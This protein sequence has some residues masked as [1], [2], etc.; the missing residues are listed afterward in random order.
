MSHLWFYY[1]SFTRLLWVCVFCIFAAS[2]AYAQTAPVNFEADKVETNQDT[3]ILTASGNV[4]L[5]QDGNELR[6]DKVEYDRKTERATAT[7]HV[8]YKTADGAMHMSDYLD[9][10]DNFKKVFAEPMISQ[11]SDGSRFTA[12]VTQGDFD[13]KIE[14]SSTSFTPCNCDYEA[15]ESPI[16]DLRATKTTHNKQTSTIIH[17]NVRM[18]V[19]GLPVFYLPVLAHPDG[20]VKRRTGFLAPSVTY[21]SAEGTTISTPYYQTLGPSADVTLRPYSFQHR[22]RGIHTIYREKTDYSDLTANIYTADVATYKKQREMV[23]AIDVTHETEVGDEWRVKTNIVRTSQDTFLRRYKF[24]PRYEL[25]SQI[26]ADRIKSDRYYLVEASD[27]QGLRASDTPDKEP[28]I[29]PHIYY[30]SYQPGFRE[31]QTIRTEVSAIQLDN[32]QGHELVRWSSDIS[33][34][35]EYQLYD[36]TL[37]AEIGV[38]S[39]LYDIHKKTDPGDH[40]GEIGQANPYLSFDWRAPVA[41]ISDNGVVILEPRA[42][43]THIDGA[44]RTQ[45]LPNRD[46]ADFRLDEANLF[47]THR[48][49]GKDFVLPGTRADIGVSALADDTIFGEI[50]AFGGISR[51]LAGDTT[52]GLTTG[53]NRNYSD[54]VASLSIQP[55]NDLTISWSGRADSNDYELNESRTN[56]DWRYQSTTLNV[57]HAQLSKAHFSSSTSDREALSVKIQ[58]SF[59]DGWVGKASQNWDL[60]NGKTRRDKTRFTL[61]WTGGF[62][63]CLTLSLDYQRDSTADRDIPR[64]DEIFLVLN[65][66]YLGAISQSDFQKDK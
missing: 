28:T 43:F 5:I 3:G 24:N 6:A 48:H 54:Y 35:E 12:A 55:S 51:R 37:D 26:K 11:L 45:E 9:L 1:H 7:G 4:I 17:E 19:L 33:V 63:N 40:D 58:Q 46:S 8:I 42:K 61:A 36:G 21:S 38:M 41:A 39:S 66:K 59:P 27:L 22:G 13:T 47:L 18:H 16:W 14:M 44:D 57:E 31:N 15:G 20:T 29:L 56:L 25:K 50:N 34:Q 2:A 62:Q 30:E 53:N 64:K 49:Q 32:D 60:S 65:F 23:G 52:A 10:S